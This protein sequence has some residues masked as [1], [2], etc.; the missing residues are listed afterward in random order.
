MPLL[1]GRLKNP[2]ISSLL[3]MEQKPI[4]EVVKELRSLLQKE[5]SALQVARDNLVQEQQKNKYG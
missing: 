1:F 5:L 4:K 2:L 3:K